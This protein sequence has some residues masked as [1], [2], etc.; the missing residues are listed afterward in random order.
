VLKLNVESRAVTHSFLS[1][2][3]FASKIDFLCMEPKPFRFH[4]TERANN[5]IEQ[6]D[7]RVVA[8]DPIGV[9]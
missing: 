5:H 6:G 8:R 1:G 7:A 9:T 2:G 3:L 4:E